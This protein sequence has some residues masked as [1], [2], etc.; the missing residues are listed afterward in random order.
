MVESGADFRGL[1]MS[2][3]ALITARG[4]SKGLP[5]KNVLPLAGKPLIAWTIEAA[6][7][8]SGLNRVVVSTDDEEIA[9]CAR[10]WGADVPFMR[11]AEL[12]G[13]GTPHIDVVEHAVHWL[14][15][16]EG[17]QPDYVLLLQ[18][19]S[20][21]RTAEDIEASI[22]LA[23]ETGAPAVV[24][25]C[26]AANHPYLVKR[27][28]EDGTLAAFVPT[29][30]AYLRRQTLPPAYVL[31]GA[32]YLNRRE[33]LLRE[34]TFTPPGTLPYIMPPERSLDVD[35]RWDFYLVNLILSDRDS[36]RDSSDY[37]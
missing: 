18:P 13:D 21:L 26:E 17:T 19:T 31:N 3:L 30:I 7:A 16:N 33:V 28:L 5:R 32:V 24:S 9:D 22:K 37:A 2:I 20:P 36:H 12:A 34:H 10:R 14:E 29:E 11:P 8:S 6:L 1:N 4:G 35:T 27:I 25:V 23:G 15:I